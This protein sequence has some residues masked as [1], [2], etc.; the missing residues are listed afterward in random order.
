MATKQEI[1]GSMKRAASDAREGNFEGL[2]S[3]VSLA[4]QQA[5]KKVE[6][7]FGRFRRSF[8]KT[9]NQVSTT[10]KRH[11]GWTAGLL[12]GVGTLL[13]A[14]LFGAL[15]PRPTGMQLFGRGLRNAWGNTRGSLMSG[16]ESIQRAAH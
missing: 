6:Q 7:E 11:P 8:N 1:Q 16:F 14:A 5:S 10:A 15:R 13:G 9:A 4:A 2:K 3:D 12:F